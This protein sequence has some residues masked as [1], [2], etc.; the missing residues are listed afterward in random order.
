M[1][2]NSN[3]QKH[4]YT[5]TAKVQNYADSMLAPPP[6][7]LH[8]QDGGH[9]LLRV[10]QLSAAEP[11][12]LVPPISTAAA[13]SRS[14]SSSSKGTPPGT[15]AGGGSQSGSQ[16]VAAAAAAV[17]GPGGEAAGGSVE[18][19]EVADEGLQDRIVAVLKQSAAQAQSQVCGLAQHGAAS[20]WLQQGAGGRVEED[21][22]Q[23][24]TVT[25]LKQ[26]ATQAQSQVCCGVALHQLQSCRGRGRGA[27]RGG[28]SR[29]APAI[30]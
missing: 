8:M 7:D 13:S 27:S 16:R 22:L 17:A 1:L 23:D 15:A 20:A 3:T 30:S 19:E 5:T 10:T 26:S 2:L 12:D 14:S 28:V 9:L 24:K 4:T 21:Q 29:R 6:A 11:A 25:V 18:E